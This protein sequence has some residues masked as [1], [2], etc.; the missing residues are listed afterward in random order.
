MSDLCRREKNKL[1]GIS[2]TVTEKTGDRV[3][4]YNTTSDD[5]LK[6][7]HGLIAV[8]GKPASGKEVTRFAKERDIDAGKDPAFNAVVPASIHSRIKGTVLFVIA[9]DEECDST[10]D[11]YARLNEPISVQPRKA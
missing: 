9:F 5:N 2:C 11:N 1:S 8:Y 7:R 6:E 10:F 3:I 4:V